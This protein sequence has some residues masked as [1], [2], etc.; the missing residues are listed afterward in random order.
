MVLGVSNNMR[1]MKFCK[2]LGR[3]E[4]DTRCGLRQRTKETRGVGNTVGG[5]HSNVRKRRAMEKKLVVVVEG[6]V[7]A[8]VEREGAGVVSVLPN[9]AV[10]KQDQIRPYLRSCL[11]IIT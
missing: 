10:P 8:V 1:K 3:E 5:I 4:T 7:E 2:V 11:V 9:K 6:S